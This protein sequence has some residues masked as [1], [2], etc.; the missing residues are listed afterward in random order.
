MPQSESQAEDTE[1]REQKF[2]EGMMLGKRKRDAAIYAGY[3]AHSASQIATELLDR[4]H[5]KRQLQSYYRRDESEAMVSR[6][7]LREKLFRIANADISKAFDNEG[8]L[9]P[10]DEI[11]PEV[12][13]A[14][15]SCRVWWGKS[16]AGKAAKF[17]GSEQS[18]RTYLKLFPEPP[19]AA[20]SLQDAADEVMQEIEAMFDRFDGVG[21]DLDDDEEDDDEEE[22]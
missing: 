4:P 5:V 20:E 7:I 16:G 6:E 19:P 18:I 1:E 22:E 3:S 21:D 9:K 15:T 17:T 2:L 11:P 8:Q 12:L 13:E 10:L 14:M